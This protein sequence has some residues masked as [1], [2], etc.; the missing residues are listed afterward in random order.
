M[1]IDLNVDY[2]SELVEIIYDDTH[3]I[4]V[5]RQGNFFKFDNFDSLPDE[6][7]LMAL[8]DICKILLAAYDEQ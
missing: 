4:R 6:E 3:S 2:D 7:S 8:K 1:H 5:T